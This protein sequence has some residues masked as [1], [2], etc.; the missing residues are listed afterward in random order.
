M[1]VTPEEEATRDFFQ[2][3]QEKLSPAERMKDPQLLLGL[4]SIFAPFLMLGFAFTQG[5]VGN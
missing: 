3:N 5:W 1:F 2:S 4:F